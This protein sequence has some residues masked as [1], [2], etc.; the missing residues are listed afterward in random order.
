M[1]SGKTYFIKYDLCNM[2][3]ILCFCTGYLTGCV[4]YLFSL[5]GGW[6]ACY[7]NYTQTN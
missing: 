1:L 6:V 2:S 3:D 4:G 7:R 5:V